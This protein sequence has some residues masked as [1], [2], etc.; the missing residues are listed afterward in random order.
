[1]TWTLR[2][3]G[4]G[5]ADAIARLNHDS[6]RGYMTFAPSSWEPPAL[7]AEGSWMRERL[8]HPD[9]WCQVAEADGELVGHVA[10][11]PGTMAHSASDEP[12]LAHFWMLFVRPSHWGTGLATELHGAAVREA[13][14][15]GYSSMRLFAVAGQARARRFYER[16]GWTT[17][18]E[19]VQDDDFGLPV[20]EYRRPLDRP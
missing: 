5:D 15:R 16:E 6:F 12:G 20:V 11:M 4:L 13:A 18:G 3:G 14:A 7:E 1:V 9:V 10:F 2:E 19:P 17:A 8:G